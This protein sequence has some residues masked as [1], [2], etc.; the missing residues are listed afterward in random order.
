MENKLKNMWTNLFYDDDKEIYSLYTLRF[1][2]F[3]FIFVHHCYENVQIPIL[4]QPA[5]AVSG[6]IILSGF[7]NGYIYIKKDYKLSEVFKFTLNRIK[8]FYPLHIL[9]LITSIVMTNV[10]NYTTWA[11]ILAFTKK[12]IC[13]IFLIQSWVNDNSY[14]FGFNGVTWFLSTYIFLT[15]LTIP[16]LTLL[17]RINKKKHGSILLA[18]LSFILFGMTTAIIYILIKTN[19]YERINGEFWT[20]VFPPARLFEYTIA[21]I[22]GIIISG[23]SF[24]FKYNKFLFSILE[25]T[26]V[27]G[28]YYYIQ[29]YSGVSNFMNILNSRLNAWIIPTI[30]LV[31]LL[32]INKGILSRLFSFKITVYLGK[33]SMYMFI[34]HQVVIRYISNSAGSVAHIRYLALY[35]LIITIALSCII[36]RYYKNKMSTQAK[37]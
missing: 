20:Y 19:I 34:I 12:L 5:F 24:E 8:K 18:I 21:M 16:I 36:D 1:I 31:I 9:L 6:F 26:L 23:K 32:T 10:F 25:I 30:L 7:L 13:N 11:Q 27:V 17:K 14:Y 3:I 35:M 2:F 37:L 22:W 15:I 28:I 33:I 4:R 29:L